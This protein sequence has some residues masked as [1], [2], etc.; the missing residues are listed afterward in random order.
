M[1]KVVF[2]IHSEWAFGSIHSEL[3][4]RMYAYD[5]DGALLPWETQ[6]TC[7]EIK[8]LDQ[9][10]DIFVSSP[11][12]Y[13]TLSGCVDIGKI[14]L[15]A[16]GP[17]DLYQFDKYN[18][19]LDTI[20][21]FGVVS[22]FLQELSEKILGVKPEILP[23]GINTNRF[24]GQ[25]AKELKTIGFASKFARSDPHLP[26]D[27]KRGHVAQECAKRTGLQFLVAENYHNTFV[28]MPGYYHSIDC[29]LIPSLEEGAGLPSLEAGAAG[30]LVIG[31][32]V[33][34][35]NERVMDEGGVT[36]SID[37][38]IEEA[39]NH[40]EFYQQN[41][42]EFAKKCESIQNWASKNYDWEQN[43]QP[44]VEFMK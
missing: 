37:N 6:Y 15:I 31:T 28:T 4:K 22:K 7:E 8:E 10:T 11:H 27:W 39:V 17:N 26:V 23:L 29:L 1:K 5:L 18:I 34:H 44:W 16:H 30:R 41:K 43:I 33:G 2:Y 9:I 25:P 12:G 32:P 19:S 3:I 42:S 36:V 13:D 14:Y 40:I 38:F 35:W 21:G 24:S 20:G